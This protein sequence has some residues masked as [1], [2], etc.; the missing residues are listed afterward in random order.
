[1]THPV[2]W[3]PHQGIPENPMEKK[4]RKGQAADGAIYNRFTGDG[5]PS[6]VVGIGAGAGALKSLKKI[7]GGLPSGRGVAVVLIHH[8]D[9]T[10]KNLLKLLEGQTTLEVVEAADGMAVLADCIY[11]V[12]PDKFLNIAQNRL[13]FSAPIHCNGLLM[14]ID[15][16]FCS[17]ADDRRN[18]CCG[19]LLSGGGDG[20]LGLSEIRAAGGQTIVEDPKNAKFPDMLQSAINA[21]VADAVLPADAIAAAVTDLAGRMIAATRNDKAASPEGDAGLEAVLDILRARVGHD[22]R[23]YKPGTL[24]RRIRRRMTLGKISTMD[25]YAR[26]LFEHPAEVGLLQGDLLIGVTDFFRQPHAWE[27][28]KKRVIT[29]LVEDAAPG[30]EIRVWVPGCASGKEV[31][32]LAMLLAE[33]AEKSGG[34][35]N[36]QIFATDADFAALAEARTGSY[37]VEEIGENISAERLKRF[38]SRRDG[39]YQAVKSLRERVVF[40]AQNITADPPFS[41]LD[42][43]VCRNLLIYLDQQIQKKIIALF[44]FALRD[45][46][47]LFLGNAETV[48]DRE[49]LFEPVE[50]K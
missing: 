31:Y 19:I 1:M 42:L 9:L 25:D 34:K 11:V 23:C 29:E 14:P 13:T 22:F 33:Q 48:G 35:T 17:L 28:L 3:T 38:F 10:K 36:F 44:H 20:T 24:V 16:F 26:H 7:L 2:L 8:P 18:R 46:G 12:P 5:S 47:F 41:R 40:A 50:K 49:D 15:H 30:T 32:S 6:V 39:R 37:P 43:I 45:G 4:I 27:T 21:G